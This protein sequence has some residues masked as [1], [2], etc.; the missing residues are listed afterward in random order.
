MN[1]HNE[2]ML[3]Q[4]EQW[5]VASDNAA[6]LSALLKLLSAKPA[7]MM[8]WRLNHG[9]VKLI[10]LESLKG[11]VA[12]A[13][14]KDAPLV[15]VHVNNHP[16]ETAV[17]R[18]SLSMTAG[19]DDRA[20]RLRVSEWNQAD[21]KALL[22][23]LAR[24]DSWVV[25]GWAHSA[26]NCVPVLHAA[27]GLPESEREHEQAFRT[28]AETEDAASLLQTAHELDD[29]LAENAAIEAQWKSLAPQPEP[30]EEPLLIWRQPLPNRA[31]SVPTQASNGLFVLSATSEVSS[32]SST[33]EIELA[34]WNGVAAR[35][36]AK[37]AAAYEARLM[38]QSSGPYAQLRLELHL[39]NPSEWQYSTGLQ[40]WLFPFQMRP[41]LVRLGHAVDGKL[42]SGRRVLSGKLPSLL[43]DDVE[44]LRALPQSRLQ[45]NSEEISAIK[46]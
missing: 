31:R 40:V 20:L 43:F 1:T 5:L 35:G 12:V 29:V 15:H 14:S 7:S 2:S 8:A 32:S 46:P 3:L 37:P 30:G 19:G 41:L 9:L 6:S 45:L 42:E 11:A 24:P 34:R 16:E 44:R 17:L 36:P 33:A 10:D 25:L 13:L 21:P 39:L 38:S 22:D 26:D 4:P 27:A 18:Q 23:E 28:W